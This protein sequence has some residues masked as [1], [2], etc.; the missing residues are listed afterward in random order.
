MVIQVIL[1]Q[2]LAK[3]ITQLMVPVSS[4]TRSILK[5][6]NSCIPKAAALV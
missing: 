2:S 4:E 1:S 6:V 5:D 3:A